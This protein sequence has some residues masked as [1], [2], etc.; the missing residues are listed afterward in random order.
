VAVPIAGGAEKVAEVGCGRALVVAVITETVAQLGVKE[1]SITGAATGEAAEEAIEVTAEEELTIEV[2]LVSLEAGDTTT[3]AAAR[4]LA[5]EAA[6]EVAVK[7]LV[8]EVTAEG[9]AKSVTVASFIELSPE[10][11]LGWF[12]DFP[13][14]VI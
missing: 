3:G 4:E 12:R 8:I 11:A 10:I 7:E 2:T 14:N 6:A 5:S 1:E 9:F 13:E